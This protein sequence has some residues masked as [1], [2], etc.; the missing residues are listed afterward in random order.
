MGNPAGD[1]DSG[2]SQQQSAI[3][4]SFFDTLFNP[5]QTQNVVYVSVSERINQSPFCEFGTHNLSNGSLRGI[6]APSLFRFVFRHFFN[7]D[8]PETSTGDINVQLLFDELVAYLPVKAHVQEPIQLTIEL[9]SRAFYECRMNG[10]E[11]CFY[12]QTHLWRHFQRSHSGSEQAK[13]GSTSP[14]SVNLAHTISQMAPFEAYAHPLSSGSSS[15][16][17]STQ[18]TQKPYAPQSFV[19]KTIHNKSSTGDINV[20]LLFDELVAYLPV[21]AHVQEPIQLTIELHP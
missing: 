5:Q 3:N 4:Q 18:T 10:C 13:S 7:S 11:I 2:L 16:T 21:K 20:Q 17:S 6:C 14:L 15:G 19:L 1:M 12:T 9:P 8:H